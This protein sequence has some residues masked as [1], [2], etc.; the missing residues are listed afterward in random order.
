MSTPN[1]VSTVAFRPF[2]SEAHP[3]LAQLNSAFANLSAVVTFLYTLI[4]FGPPQGMACTNQDDDRTRHGKIAELA[5][6]LREL[7]SLQEAL[8]TA[9]IPVEAII[10]A[11]DTEEDVSLLAQFNTWGAAD[12]V[13]KA[14]ELREAAHAQLKAD[15]RKA[16]VAIN[17]GHSRSLSAIDEVA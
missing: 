7:P 10:T 6:R 4:D 16:K 8:R 12:L 5:V 13:L 17:V 15:L 11:A 3:T 1:R 14:S 9:I 2:T